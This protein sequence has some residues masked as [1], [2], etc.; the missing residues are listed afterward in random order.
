MGQPAVHKVHSTLNG[1]EQR[2][3]DESFD[4]GLQGLNKELLFSETAF[5]KTKAGKLICLIRLNFAV[6]VLSRCASTSHIC[7]DFKDFNIHFMLKNN[8]K[9]CRFTGH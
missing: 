3:S 5:L 8:N 7:M 2:Y 4:I 9:R 1:I 6:A